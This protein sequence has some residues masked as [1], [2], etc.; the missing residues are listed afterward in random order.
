MTRYRTAALAVCLL[1]ATN[2]ASAQSF[3]DDLKPLVRE[4]CVRCHGVRTVTPLNL[5]GLGY[6]LTD[7]KTRKTWEKIYERLER[8]EMPPATANSVM[9]WVSTSRRLPIM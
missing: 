8:G 4:S 3:E 7:H 1:G 6:D 2:T 5:V 9:S